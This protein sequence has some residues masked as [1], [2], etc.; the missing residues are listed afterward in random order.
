M[1]MGGVGLDAHENMQLM[2]TLGH[3]GFQAFKEAGKSANIVEAVKTALVGGHQ[4][5]GANTAFLGMAAAPVL[6]ALA[7]ISK[8]VTHALDFFK[9]LSTRADV[10][11]VAEIKTQ[12]N[13]H[14]DS[15]NAAV[16]RGAGA[17]N[18]FAAFNQAISE[19][20]D[21]RPTLS[22]APKLSM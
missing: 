5:I 14:F 7:A 19:K 3:E 16:E 4:T 21:N 22:R 20:E 2:D 12:F 11:D 8:G 10:S 15:M 13:S 17:S 1:I 9:G 18:N 6:P